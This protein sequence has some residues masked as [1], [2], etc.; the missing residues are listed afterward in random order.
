MPATVGAIVSR[1]QIDPGDVGPTVN[2]SID[3]LERRPELRASHSMESYAGR[4][5]FVVVIQSLLVQL[6][7]PGQGRENV[8][9]ERFRDPAAVDAKAV[10]MK[11]ETKGG[12]GNG[13][14]VV[15]RIQVRP[16]QHHLKLETI[17]HQWRAD[18]R[19]ARDL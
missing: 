18:Q 8:P 11:V 13:R 17:N 7:L 5:F 3:R 2:R 16:R 10:T 14:D 4:E 12:V 9:L 15:D 6:Q 1:I 19:P